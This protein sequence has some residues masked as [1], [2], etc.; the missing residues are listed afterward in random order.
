MDTESGWKRQL[1]ELDTEPIER[2]EED[3]N[4]VRYNN[5]K[6][7]APGIWTDEASKTPTWYS[8]DGISNLEPEFDSEFDG[9]PLNIMH[10]VD[11]ETGEVN[12]ASLAGHIDPESIHTTSDGELVSDW[13][14]DTSTGAGQ[15]ADENMQSALASEGKRGFGGPS[16]ELDFANPHEDLRY[17]AEKGVEEMVRG[18]LKGAALVMNPADRTVDFSREAARRPVAMSDGSQTIKTLSKRSERMESDELKRKLGLDEDVDLDEE[19]IQ[20]LA[21]AD[22][23]TL[24]D[25]EE[26]EEE[27]AEAEEDNEGEEEE[28]EE[29]M[30]M[31]E[32]E[33]KMQNLE[34][35]LQNLED[36]MDSVMAQ[37]D[38]EELEAELSEEVE[39]ATQELADAETV[40]ELQEAKDELDK[41][42]SKLE[43]EP[44]GPKTLSGNGES[45]ELGNLT[46]IEP[47]TSTF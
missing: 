47:R 20:T 23:L 31:A 37:E 11:I 13:V 14:F 10:D 1:S 16:V 24:E 43:D 46:S 28:E 7:L 30:D 22:A 27:E 38:A 8:P 17:N 42:L 33:D 35:R 39:E 19:T 9:P 4:T 21:E 36:M 3:E 15:F 40:Q 18:L 26:E 41:R 29:G 2:V 44:K 34:E 45:D 6:M 5:V 12:E 32:A 25:D